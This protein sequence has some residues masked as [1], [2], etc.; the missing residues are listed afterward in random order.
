[1]SI[2]DL[3]KIIYNEIKKK[4]KKEEKL[5]ARAFNLFYL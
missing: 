3:E 4:K 5:V 2:N 1:M